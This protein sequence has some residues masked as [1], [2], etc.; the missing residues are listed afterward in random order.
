MKFDVSSE[1]LDSEPQL[2]NISL[3]EDKL[4]ACIGLNCQELQDLLASPNAKKRDALFGKVLR[5]TTTFKP[6]GLT[7]FRIFGTRVS[8][9]SCYVCC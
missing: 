4:K 6:H 7:M 9:L 2:G 3:N 5:R 8:E 1:L